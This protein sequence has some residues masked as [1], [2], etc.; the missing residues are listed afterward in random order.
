MTDTPAEGGSYIVDPVT[1]ERRREGGTAPA[2]T[3]AE[4]AAMA[5]AAAETPPAAAPAAPQ[6]NDEPPRRRAGKE[7]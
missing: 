5:P 2:P 6:T 3:P 7:G 1:G 4:R